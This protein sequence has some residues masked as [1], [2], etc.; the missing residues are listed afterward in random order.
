MKITETELTH[1]QKL[2]INKWKKYQEELAFYKQEEMKLR[3]EITE[4]CFPTAELGTTT[5]ELGAGYLLKAVIKQNTS[6]DIATLLN[7][8]LPEGV[9]DKIIDYKPTLVQAE[10]KKLEG[11]NLRLA[12]SSITVKDGAPTVTL[13]APKEKK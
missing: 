7:S 11:K 10:F 5:I 12:S 6:V 9:I 8:G 3:K 1:A 13:V 2:K 4:E